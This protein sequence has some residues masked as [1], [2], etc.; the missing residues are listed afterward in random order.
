MFIFAVILAFIVGRVTA[1]LPSNAFLVKD[2]SEYRE[3]DAAEMVLEGLIC[4]QEME[5]AEADWS[6]LTDTAKGDCRLWA[7]II[8]AA[9]EAAGDPDPVL[10]PRDPR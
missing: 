8:V 9:Q 7:R 6:R 1:P 3:P 10:A 2:A 5:V 4:Y